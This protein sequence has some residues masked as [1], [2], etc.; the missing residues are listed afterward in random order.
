MYVPF[1]EQWYASLAEC[2]LQLI[3][4]IVAMNEYVPPVRPAQT[5]SQG[6]WYAIMAATFYMLGSM[7]LMI[8]MLGYFL[9]H[10]PQ[11]FDLDDDQRTLILQTMMFFIWLAG[12]AGIFSKV[13]GYSYVDALYFCD[14]T[15]LTVGFGD[16]VANNTASRAILMP[17]S[18]GGIISLGLVINSIRKFSANI[19]RDNVIKKHQRHERERTWSNTVTSEKE[20][21]SRLGLPPRRSEESTRPHL[22]ASGGRLSFERYGHLDIQG[23]KVTFHEGNKGA[24]HK[25]EGKDAGKD[26]GNSFERAKAISQEAWLQAREAGNNKES[27]RQRK[28][29]KLLL[30]RE[31]KD[32]FDE[33]RRIQKNTNRFKQYYALSWS[34]FAYGVLWCVGSLVFMK[35]EAR[36]QG[37]TYFE[38][39]YFCYVSLL[40]IGYGDFSPKSNAGK[41][42]FVVWSLLAVPTMTILISD[43]SDT[44]VDGVD[45][46][47]SLLADWT[48]MPKAGVW[49]DFVEK[50]PRLKG[51]IQRKRE[52]RQEKKRVEAGFTVQDPDDPEANAD[53]TDPTP[54][55]AGHNGRG[56]LSLESLA[57]ERAPSESSHELARR[58]ALAIKR[59]SRDTRAN[60]DRKYSYEE[61][62]EFT[63]L[64]RFSALNPEEVEEEEEQEGLVEWDWIGENSPMLADV[65]ESEWVLDRLCESLNRYTRHQAAAEVSTLSSQPVTPVGHIYWLC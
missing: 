51:W 1:P 38:S 47:T 15:V 56:Q 53:P 35:A 4:I 5:Y 2:L 17:Y 65:S 29:A 62:V 20:L 24:T 60:N 18:V 57:S 7:L 46:G 39:L 61:W 54:Y 27:R 63:R 44:I 59:V 13:C 32:R 23:R 41:P 28:R 43:M 52:E 10:Y 33:M 22:Y 37:L 16:F 34:V 11:H 40:S 49:H 58:L 19:S 64:I 45:R 14:V 3:A 9:G 8:N 36:L 50:H 26:A 42:F 12:G 55:A 31:E 48:I 25:H 30:L 21:R 6:F